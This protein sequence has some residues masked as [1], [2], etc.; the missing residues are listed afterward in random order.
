M[1]D[2]TYLFS[3]ERRF[4]LIATCI[5]GQLGIEHLKTSLPPFFDIR[6]P[7]GDTSAK[8]HYLL[9]VKTQPSR[10]KHNLLAE[11]VLK[12]VLPDPHLLSSP[13]ESVSR[14]MRQISDPTGV[15][16]EPPLATPL[17]ARRSNC[18]VL[19]IVLPSPTVLVKNKAVPLRL[20][21]NSPRG[22]AI[23][24]PVE[25]RRLVITLRTRASVNVA[26]ERAAW[27]TSKNIS[28]A[29]GWRI[30]VIRSCEHE[31]SFEVDI[32]L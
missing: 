28:R 4:L 18:V 26:D 10:F 29:T 16:D 31:T 9:R 24:D 23:S 3:F 14:T 11:I 2:G 32:S 21:M 19:E 1:S 30:P 25:L 15:A 17:L 6:S 7:E 13:L 5:S 8:L 27:A 22:L 20:F 12:F